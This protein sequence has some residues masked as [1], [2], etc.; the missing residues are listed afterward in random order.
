MI[1][2]ETFA[3][4][5][6]SNYWPSAGPPLSSSVTILLPGQD[7]PA[8]SGPM[9]R[10]TCFVVDC[11]VRF[12]VCGLDEFRKPQVGFLSSQSNSL[13]FKTQKGYQRWLDRLP[14]TARIERPS[15]FSMILPSLLASPPWNGTRVGPTAAVERALLFH[16][17]H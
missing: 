1:N 3:T 16:H 6:G 13:N 11:G 9:S 4:L 10:A 2:G 7:K 12:S 14:Y 15:S 17:L 8:P 5:S